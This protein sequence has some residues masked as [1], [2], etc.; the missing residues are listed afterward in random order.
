M[1]D[2]SC[3][4]LSASLQNGLS[5]YGHVFSTHHFIGTINSIKSPLNFHTFHLFHVKKFNNSLY[6]TIGGK[7]LLYS[8]CYYVR[9]V[10]VVYESSGSKT[11]CCLTTFTKIPWKFHVLPPNGVFIWSSR[12]QGGKMTHGG[13]MT[14]ALF[15]QVS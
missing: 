4:C 14:F 13:K 1:N 5:I 3:V 12:V 8:H 11:Q 10:V 9:K 2:Q 7:V 15:S 6:F